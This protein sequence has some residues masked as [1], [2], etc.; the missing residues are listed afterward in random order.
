MASATI[1]CI[2]LNVVNR[3]TKITAYDNHTLILLIVN[4]IIREQQTVCLLKLHYEVSYLEMVGRRGHWGEV[5]HGIRDRSSAAVQ[6]TCLCEWGAERGMEFSGARKSL[7][8][9]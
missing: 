5:C 6:R 9:I 8:S 3:S 1:H 2:F 4:G 7:S